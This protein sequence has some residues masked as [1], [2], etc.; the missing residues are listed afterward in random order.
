[1]VPSEMSLMARKTL[2]KSLKFDSDDLVLYIDFGIA[3]IVLLL[4][5]ISIFLYSTGWW[6]KLMKTHQQSQDPE[7]PEN[8]ITVVSDDL[9]VPCLGE[10]EPNESVY[11]VDFA[12]NRS[13]KNPIM[14]VSIIPTVPTELFVLDDAESA[15]NYVYVSFVTHQLVVCCHHLFL[16]FLYITL[17]RILVTDE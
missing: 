4:L 7:N 9:T 16:F 11:H 17:I 15:D 2:V 13:Y 5:I 8:V 12:H 3:V 6:S 10:S 1:M 14:S